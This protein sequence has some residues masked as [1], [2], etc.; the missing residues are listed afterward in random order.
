MI[1]IQILCNLKCR[2]LLFWLC[3]AEKNVDALVVGKL[4]TVHCICLLNIVGTSYTTL[5]IF[6]NWIYYQ[7]LEVIIFIY[8]E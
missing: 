6:L 8:L 4:G 3:K 5:F 2:Y 1:R 7:I